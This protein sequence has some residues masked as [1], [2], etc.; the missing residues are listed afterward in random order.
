MQ[1]LVLVGT[2]GALGALA[3][4]G[5]S[6]F[7]Q[8]RAGTDFPLGTLVVNVLGCLVLGALMTLVV[9]KELFDVRVRQFV[10][11]GLLGS[12]TTFSTFGVET[13]ELAR[14]GQVGAAVGNVALNVL[15]GVGAVLLGHAL[16]RMVVE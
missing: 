13:V 11:V 2:G 9:E 1:T 4:F 16:V 6:A 8:R 14:E 12:F 7:V 15:V 5:L 10:G 3:R